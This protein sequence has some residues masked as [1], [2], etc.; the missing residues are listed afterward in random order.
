MKA[1]LTFV[2][3]TVLQAV[4]LAQKGSAYQVKEYS[5]D[6]G[7]PS[8]GI[9]GLQWDEATG[10]LWIAT[11]A[12][13]SRFNG[14]DFTNFTIENTPGLSHE[15]MAFMVKNNAGT[16]YTSDVNGN[17]FSIN[18]STIT[19]DKFPMLKKIDGLKK[20]HILATT[21]NDMQQIVLACMLER[22]NEQWSRL[23]QLS[24]SS[25]IFISGN[26][27]VYFASLNTMKFVP[28]TIPFLFS[29]YFVINGQLFLTDANKRIYLAKNNF[30]TFEPVRFV[31]SGDKPVPFTPGISLF[32]WENGMGNPILFSGNNAWLLHYRNNSIEAELICSAVPTSSY[33]LSAQYSTKNKTLFIGTDSKGIVVIH[34]NRVMSVK[35]KNTDIRERN[36]FYSQIELPDGNILTNEGHIIGSAPSFPVST[37]VKGKFNYTTYANGDSLWFAQINSRFGITL[38]HCYNYKTGQTV[39]YNKIGAIQES[40]AMTHSGGRIYLATSKGLGYFQ[41]DS[42]HYLFKPSP[43]KGV[44]AAP[45]TMTEFSPGVLGVASCDGLILYN[46][47]TPATDTV[48]KM[49]GY[50]VRSLWKHKDYVFIGTYGKGFYMWKDGRVKAMPTDKNNFLFYAHCFVP[51]KDG[52]C[53]ISTNRGLIQGTTIRPD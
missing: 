30:Q 49:P 22:G 13:I 4:S 26:R 37:P 42:I 18:A 33:I 1:I 40:F 53:W 34:E 16:I 20:R 15:R 11:E 8:N 12:G 29:G 14:I 52:F 28:V 25:V 48:L 3:F 10:F 31:S 50:C 2:C 47:N 38:L 9:K 23:L 19:Y 41:N 35:K 39:V 46:V 32:Y 27:S 43:Q 17:I 21:G 44:Q 7:L 5:T 45:Y 6:N 36:S 24:D 51:D